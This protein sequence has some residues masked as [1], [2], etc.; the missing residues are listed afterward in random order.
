MRQAGLRRGEAC[1]RPGRENAESGRGDALLLRAIP[2]DGHGTGGPRCCH[3]EA[4]G[5]NDKLCDT[6]THRTKRSRCDP[7]QSR[8]RVVHEARA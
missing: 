7:I 1:P 3:C 2:A 4:A 5:E 8:D 6:P